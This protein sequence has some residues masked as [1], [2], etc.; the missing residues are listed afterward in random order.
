MN[1]CFCMLSACSQSKIVNKHNNTNSCQMIAINEFNHYSQIHIITIGD[2]HI[3]PK[4][5]VHN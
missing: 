4:F 2:V 5:N 1:I 3:R